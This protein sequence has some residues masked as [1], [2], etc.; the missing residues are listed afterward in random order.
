MYLS[1]NLYLYSPASF[2]CW[3]GFNVHRFSSFLLHKRNIRHGMP[4]RMNGM[5]RSG[6][7]FMNSA[8]QHTQFVWVLD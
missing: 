1:T 2:H 5:E 7:L 4:G 3:N 8:V 6:R